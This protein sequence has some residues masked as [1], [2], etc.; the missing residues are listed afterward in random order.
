MNHHR[1]TLKSAT[2]LRD[3]R[4]LTSDD[5][6]A[7]PESDYFALR[8]EVTRAHRRGEALYAC[9]LCGHSVYAPLVPSTQKPFWRHHAGAPAD[10]P[11]WTGDPMGVDRVSA[12]QFRGAQESPLH[13]RVKAI[14][15]RMLEADPA[16]EPGSVV[17]DRYLEG[18]EGRRRPDV[19]ATVSGRPL[20]FE[21]Q[22]ATTQVPI[23]V[24]R[25]DFYARE[26]RSLLWLTWAFDP[27]RFIPASFKDILHSHN[28][29]LFSLDE[30]VLTAAERSGNFTLKAFRRV[31]DDGWSAELCEL[32]DLVWPTH[33]LAHLPDRELAWILEFRRRW[34]TSR[35]P[36]GTEP[37]EEAGLVSELLAVTPAPEVSRRDVAS[38]LDFLASVHEGKPIASAQRNLRALLH[39]FLE[40]DRRRR[41]ARL[42]RYALASCK[43]QDVLDDFKVAGKL[44]ARMRENEQETRDGPMGRV[45]LFLYP[46]W[47]SAD[48]KGGR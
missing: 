16:T 12:L 40:P 39:T 15:A 28:G 23:I 29:T 8:H 47:F 30:E 36:D 11:W 17:V 14:V 33:G 37:P 4:P 10:C 3:M 24:A 46:E 34:A 22:L 1:R 48:G 21:I 13:L 45:V 35:R 41:Y 43:R 44:S 9:A 5:L 42:A 26:R 32:T 27:S 31:A 18:V 2:R 20:T 25:E 6:L 19:R 38:V 7:M